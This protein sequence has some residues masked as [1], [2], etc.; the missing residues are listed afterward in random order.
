MTL[1]R[2]A[3][4]RD[5]V[6]GPLS[7]KLQIVAANKIDALDEPERLER[8]RQHVVQ[9]GLEMYSVSAVTGQGIT[10]LLEAIWTAFT[11]RAPDASDLDTTTPV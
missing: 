2:D 5:A 7:N 4:A 1:F 11:T 3:T 6:G 8:L 10:V 9:L